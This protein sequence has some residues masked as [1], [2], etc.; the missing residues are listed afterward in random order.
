MTRT[1]YNN[2]RNSSSG[3]PVCLRMSDSVPFASSLCIGTTVLKTRS[4]V[5]FSRETWLPFWRNSTKP[6]LFRA[7]TTR[8]PETLGSLGISTRNFDGGPE[9]F[10][11]RRCPLRNAPGFDVQFNG[12]AKAGT[13][14]LD[15]FSLGSD[16]QLRAAR[17]IPAVFFG[18]QRRK[19]VCHKPMLADEPLRSKVLERDVLRSC[20]LE[21][22]D[23]RTH[24]RRDK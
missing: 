8:S 22:T 12:F 6:A 4:D 15:I 17:D 9:R 23:T 19:S 1:R 11:F 2:F 7:R 24:G 10:A 18:N 5:R 16:V 13:R 21:V 3:R 20:L 14:A